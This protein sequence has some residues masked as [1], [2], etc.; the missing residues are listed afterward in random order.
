MAEFN[1]PQCGSTTNDD[2]T[3]EIT[4]EWL[5]AVGFSQDGRSFVM[6]PDGGDCRC[7]LSAFV[8]DP[9]TWL[10]T[11]NSDIDLAVS[12]ERSYA[13]T[14]GDVRLLCRVLGVEL[15]EPQQ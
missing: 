5:R 2:D 13:T 3:L 7:L 11:G 9:K 6:A 12:I 8:N 14:R 15:K 1:C 4:A 10:F